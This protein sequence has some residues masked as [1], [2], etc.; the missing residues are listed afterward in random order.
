VIGGLIL[1]AVGLCLV[2]VISA[3]INI[4]LRRPLR[5]RLEQR[6]RSRGRADLIERLESA[7]HDLTLCA[8][9]LR[10][11]STLALVMVVLR[12]FAILWPLAPLAQYGFAFLALFVML[13]VFGI[14]APSAWSKYA[15]E[16]LLTA[17]LPTMLAVIILFR[18]LIAVVSLIDDLVRR[19][20]DVPREE[21]EDESRHEQELLDAVSEGERMGAVDEIERGMI[22]SIMDLRDTD[23]SEIMTPRTDIKAAEKT[24]SLAEVKHLIKE[25][26]HSRIPIFDE[27]IDNVLGI[28][29][30]KD[31]L[32]LDDS[33][34]FDATSAMRDPLFIPETKH[35]R[36]LLT[37]FRTRKVHM[38]IVLDE[39]GGTAGLVTIEDILE[40]LVGEIVDEYDID[41][42]EPI[43]R[44]DEDTV[45]VDARM[46]IDDINEELEFD[47][48]EDD[49]Y[50]TLGGFI[51]A[52]MGHIPT[53]GEQCEHE[54]IAIQIIDAEP[55][56]INRVRLIRHPAPIENNGD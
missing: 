5:S 14:A 11:A 32:D 44:I 26:G 8:A 25:I 43:T 16:S 3:T 42:P 40:E 41:E 7:R 33:D 6:L 37:E 13:L 31:L 1:G 48:P 17:L 4:T 39:Y 55:R 29:Y 54:N 46:R 53:V 22:Q 20:A 34:S 28:L 47:L 50:E 51:F 35:L 38:A 24:A 2:L 18:P 23:V 45:E 21:D 19:L 12:V 49:D 10:T 9:M 56:R 15:G 36:D 52:R 30:A 27:T